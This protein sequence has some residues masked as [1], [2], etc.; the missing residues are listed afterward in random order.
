MSY[1]ILVL[2][3]L[4]TIHFVYESIIAPSLRLSIRY[5]LF[6]LRDQLRSLKIEHAD[7]LDDKHFHYLQD[8]INSIILALPRID[9]M[10]I[11]HV[12]N[13]IEKDAALKERLIARQKIL[14]DCT[15]PELRG[16]RK[17]SIELSVVALGVNS[18]MWAIYVIPAMAVGGIYKSIER[19]I[20]ALISLSEIDLQKI[21]PEVH[22]NGA[23]S[24]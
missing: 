8:S 15:I 17:K 19:R 10:T 7:Q 22:Q 18:G 3:S 12:K 6:A 4:A 13:A 11:A 14:D 23:F 21:A 2:V 9:A 20:K 1:L 24:N 16:I 5:D